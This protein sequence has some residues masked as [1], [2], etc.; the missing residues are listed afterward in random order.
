MIFQNKLLEFFKMLFFRLENNTKFECNFDSRSTLISK[1]NRC[2]L[3]LSYHFPK[4]YLGLIFVLKLK[5]LVHQLRKLCQNSN[6][7]I[8]ILIAIKNI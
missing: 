7:A 6:I 4:I 2:Q 3:L 8:Y 5:I 1:V